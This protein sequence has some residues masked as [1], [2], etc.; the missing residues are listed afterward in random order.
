MVAT[1]FLVIGLSTIWLAR[2]ISEEIHRIACMI[3]GIILVILSLFWVA[4]FLQM[5]IELALLMMGFV[6]MSLLDGE[7]IGS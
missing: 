1:L 7:K 2:C 6:G 5:S 3:T 4:P